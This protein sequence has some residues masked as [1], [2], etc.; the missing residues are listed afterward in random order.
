MIVVNKARYRSPYGCVSEYSNL[1]IPSKAFK[2]TQKPGYSQAYRSYLQ[3]KVD[4]SRG[5]PE[6]A[7]RKQYACIQQ[8]SADEYVS[9]PNGWAG[10]FPKY[11]FDRMATA[12]PCESSVDKTCG[13]ASETPCLV[14]AGFGYHLIGELTPGFWQYPAQRN[15]DIQQW[16]Q[17]H[18]NFIVQAVQPCF[19]ELLNDPLF[20]SDCGRWGS[21][22]CEWWDVLR[23][24]VAEYSTIGAVVT[25]R[26]ISQAAS[27]PRIYWNEAQALIQSVGGDIERVRSQLRLAL[28]APPSFSE[29]F[30]AQLESVSV[31][32]VRLTGNRFFLLP[33]IPYQI[34]IIDKS[35][36]QLTKSASV[37][38]E[39][40]LSVDASIATITPTGIL[41]IHKIQL[42]TVADRKALYVIV[43][44]GSE[45]SVGQ[46]AIYD[47]DQDGDQLNDTYENSLGL[48]SSIR[49]DGFSDL[50]HD[51]LLDQYEAVLGTNPLSPD[52]DGDDYTDAFEVKHG[53][54]PC[55]PSS[56]PQ[57]IQSIRDGSW[58]TT[59]TWSCQCV[60]QAGD[61]V[62]IKHGHS[63]R[64]NSNT[65]TVESVLNE[66]KLTFEN[67]AKLNMKN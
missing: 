17:D 53:S 2:P 39:Y 65:A 66:G 20:K 63:I 34:N 40:M 37:N 49:N 22:T 47:N 13:L 21:T 42:P 35:G 3:N 8:R 52:T 12:N 9:D 25:L 41:T 57:Y 29:L 16:T 30:S 14:E 26:E 58:S 11:L 54:N 46:F 27:L 36:T 56:V 5:K 6:Y 62:W 59:A 18:N 60:P 45:Y 50:D 1:I 10:R 61:L 7:Y 32:L 19:D 64:V 28:P 38:A 44:Q 51:N 55:N 23:G 67:G 4:E 31:H 15:R 48:S 43:K 33:N 24:R